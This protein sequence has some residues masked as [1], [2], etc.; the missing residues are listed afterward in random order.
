M[1]L[2]TIL[3]ALSTSVGLDVKALRS[4]QGT[5]ATLTTTEKNNLVGALNELRALVLTHVS[6]DDVTPSDTTTYSSNKIISEITT[7]TSALLDVEHSYTHN[8]GV[9]SAVWSV[10]HPL[11]KLPAVAVIDSAGN[12]VEGSVKYI[13]NNNLEITFSSA[14]AGQAHLN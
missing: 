10:A 3:S 9:A 8:Q 4:G 2:E 5:L 13:D 7:A 12:L 1:S 11:N 14:F 6:I